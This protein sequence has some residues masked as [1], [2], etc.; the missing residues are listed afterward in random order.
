MQY[1]VAI[2]KTLVQNCT[3]CAYSL[4]DNI[5]RD[6]RFVNVNRFIY[7]CTCLQHNIASLWIMVM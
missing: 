3:N 7:P 4:V 6:V 1:N 2:Q 5:N